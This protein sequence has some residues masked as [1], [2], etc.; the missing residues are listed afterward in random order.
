LIVDKNDPEDPLLSY[1][2][3]RLGTVLKEAGEDKAAIE[4]LGKVQNKTPSVY[5]AAQA[6]MGKIM[7]KTDPEAAIKNYERIVQQSETAE[8][9][10]L[11]MVGIG[12]VYVTVKKWKQAA[13]TYEKVHAFYHGSDTTLL[14]GCIVKW[15]D[16]LSN[17]KQYDKAIKTAGIMQ[18]QFPDNEFAINAWYFEAQS[19]MSLKKYSQARKTFDEIIKLNK[20]ALFTEIAYYQRGDCSFF[21]K[22]FKTAIREYDEYLKKYPEGK[23]RSAAYYMQGNAYWSQ[24]NFKGADEKF[25]TV[26]TKY[27]DFSDVCG[28][29]NNWAYSLYKT[30][31]AKEALKIYNEVISGGGCSDKARTEARDKKETILTTQQ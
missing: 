16:A 21:G 4:A 2:A 31:R 19:W 14:A 23:Y 15:I 10:A 6:E 25:R 8:D 27:P 9:S 29:K 20:S 3:Y 30:G 26:V 11:A 28:A 24:E 12:D 13:E 5:R 17:D 1:A 22:D 18:K 7:A